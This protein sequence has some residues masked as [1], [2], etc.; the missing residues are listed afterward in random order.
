MNC[1]QVR[2]LI[3]PYVKGELDDDLREQVARHFAACE[4]CSRDLQVEKLLSAPPEP[5]PREA[6][7][8]AE[9][10]L[11]AVLESPE[12]EEACLEL[13]QDPAKLEGAANEAPIIKIAHS[14]IGSAIQNGARKVTM[15]PEPQSLNISY[16]G[17][18][19]SAGQ[20]VVPKIIEAPLIARFKL[21]AGIGTEPVTR[22]RRGH[23]PVRM[24]DRDYRLRLSVTPT[25][26]GEE[27]AIVIADE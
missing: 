14:I 2:P 24:G 19:A 8:V 20:V 27:L 9:M 25:E 7:T 1:E 17:G 3:T 16:L 23:I 18:S 13:W 12:F 15:L 4:S 22:K 6:D 21:M 10:L 26:R 5:A 11:S